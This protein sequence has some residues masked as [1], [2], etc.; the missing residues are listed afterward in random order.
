MMP[1]VTNHLEREVAQ[2]EIVTIPGAGHHAHRTAPEA[3]AELIRRA[4]ELG[5]ST[6]SAP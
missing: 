2:L 1:A 4:H 6:G 5:S 3:F